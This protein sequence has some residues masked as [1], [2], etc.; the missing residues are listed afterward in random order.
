M[1]LRVD[2]QVACGPSGSQWKLPS[3]RTLGGFLGRN[4]GGEFPFFAHC[5]AYLPDHTIHFGM[6]RQALQVARDAHGD[7]RARRAAVRAHE[8]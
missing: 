8:E 1:V 3:S 4:A 2:V 7:A 5:V 6:A